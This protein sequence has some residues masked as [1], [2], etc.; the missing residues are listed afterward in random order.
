MLWVL[1]RTVSMSSFEHPKHMLKMMGNQI[2]TIAQYFRTSKPVI[3]LNSDHKII[4][5]S[6]LP[7]LSHAPCGLVLD[8]SYLFFP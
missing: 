2:F 8:R 6:L 5:V 1:K 3:I 7:A 4:K